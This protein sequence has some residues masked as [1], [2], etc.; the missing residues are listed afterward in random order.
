MPH[1]YRVGIGKPDGSNGP[2]WELQ[3]Q[4]VVPFI[5]FLFQGEHLVRRPMRERTQK[6]PYVV[7]GQSKYSKCFSE[8]WVTQVGLVG[9]VPTELQHHTTLVDAI[10][11]AWEH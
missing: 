3:S 4:K 2:I 7:N 9:G 8:G 6:W 5:H 1:G 10:S 11:T